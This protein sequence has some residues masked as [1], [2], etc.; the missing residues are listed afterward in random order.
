MP[1][2]NNFKPAS[3]FAVVLC[4]LATLSATAIGAP[5]SNGVILLQPQTGTK[6]NQVSPE[7][8]SRVK[9]H[10]FVPQSIQGSPKVSAEPIAS[11]PFAPATKQ[12]VDQP[13]A[14][15]MGNRPVSP[16]VENSPSTTTL[17]N[18]SAVINNQDSIVRTTIE[19][20]K[21]VNL[22]KPAIVKINL[23]N[24]GRTPV[25]QVEFLVALPNA[26]KL[27]LASPEPTMVD[28]QMLQF[29]LETF[30]AAE[31]R[32]IQL[33]IVPTQRTAIDI[34]TSVRTE[35]QQNV[36]VAVREPVLQT[37]INGPSQTNLGEQVAHEV[38][39]T[40]TGDGVATQVNL[41]ATFPP[42]LVK[43]KA[44][45][46]E[47]IPVLEPGQTIKV[48]YH[49]QAIAPGPAEIQTAV[50][51]DDGVEPKTA[52]LAMTIFEPTLQISAIGP[53]VNFVNRNGIYTINLEN[54]GEVP[55]TDILVSLHVPDGLN[56]TTINRE[57]NVDAE[58]GI[59]RWTFNEVAAGSVEQIQMMAVAEKEGDLTCNISVDSHETAEKQ[60]QLA[61]NIT[62]R[63]NLNV[64]IKNDSGPV[65]VGGQAIFTVELENDGSRKAVDVNVKVELPAGLQA[66]TT[67]SQKLSISGNTISFTEPQIGPDRKVSFQFSATGLAPGEHLVRTETLI[68]GSQ[69]RMIAEDTVFVYSVDEARVSESLTPA[70]NR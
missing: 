15:L 46:S 62:T 70:V 5:Q 58:K 25:G 39:I 65:Q 57:A 27:V 33:S 36:I 30:D 54:N 59:L 48:V 23:E 51:S 3:V 56:I 45:K 2:K 6:L 50:S 20:P 14:Q 28:G 35:N 38:T 61:T 31:Q 34:A 12:I 26:A 29:N 37:T 22:N 13:N 18:N 7:T 17:K 8:V 16:A 10:G 44:S 49:S 4:G 69:R 55:V 24:T 41:R 21:F 43:S 66:V 67:D 40:N 53:K 1:I 68:E 47:L 9:R 11:V 64:S 42:N 19:S 63:A 32:Q 60:I 52:S